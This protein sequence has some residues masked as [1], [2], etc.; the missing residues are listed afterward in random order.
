MKKFYLLIGL[1]LLVTG[2]A[3][4]NPSSPPPLKEIIKENPLVYKKYTKATQRPY[5]INGKWYFP[6]MVKVGQ[7]QRGIA[8]W[9]GKDFHGKLTSNGEIYNM[10]AYT[11]AHKTFPMN[12]ILR[13]RN[14]RNNKTV[15]VRVNDRGPF[16]KS[17]II[18]LT[19]AAAKKIG[20]DKVGTAP[21]ELTVLGFGK[22]GHLNKKKEMAITSPFMVQVGAFRRKE[23]AK[24]YQKQFSK[25]KRPVII[26]Y[27]S[28]DKLNRVFIT[29]FRSEEEAKD[30]I[31]HN[32][33]YGFIVGGN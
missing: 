25:Y 20:M 2:C 26:K 3:V 30:F 18:D 23:G 4:K 14:L 31:K 12:T 17:R 19:Y 10:Y 22:I 1:L 28:S 13:V 27:F 24:I 6:T 33:I 5:K 29:G 21:V 11:A 16:V 7:K 9:Y 15:I 32:K 8:S